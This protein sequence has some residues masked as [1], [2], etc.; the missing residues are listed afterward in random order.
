MVTS[1]YY[2]G[3]QWDNMERKIIET[4]GYPDFISGAIGALSA[5][6]TAIVVI[7]ATSGVQVNTQRMWNIARD[8]GLARIV[9]IT[10]M[11]SENIDF[12]ALLDSIQNAFGPE[13]LPLML[14]IGH[15]SGFTIHL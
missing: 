11:D 8:A 7:A 10:K 12:P 4:P 3:M 2:G 6:E 14:P 15:G 1:T 9:V 5:V 13:C